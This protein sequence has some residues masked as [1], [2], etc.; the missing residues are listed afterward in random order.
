MK[1]MSLFPFLLASV[2]RAASMPAVGDTAPDAPLRALDGGATSLTAVRDG[3]PALLLFYRGGWCPYC[4]AHLAEVAT[5]E[6]ALQEKGIRIFGISPDKPEEL[7]KTV[8]K[9]KLGYTLL[10]DSSMAVSRAFGLAFT[11]DEATLATYKTYGIDLGKASGETHMQLP[12]TAAFLVD[13]HGK[14]I[15]AHQDADYR[16]RVSAQEILAAASRL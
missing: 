15:W 9:N 7:A 4:N 16:K 11:V 8:G 12:V 1:S 10:S 14:I 2:L 3:K 13:A 6:G 5:L